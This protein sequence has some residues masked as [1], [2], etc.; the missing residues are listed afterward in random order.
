LPEASLSISCCRAA[1]ASDAF[2]F[3]NFVDGPDGRQTL[4]GQRQF[5]DDYVAIVDVVSV[6]IFSIDDGLKI[7]FTAFRQNEK[8]IAERR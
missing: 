4:F 2:Q 6:R 7:E 8:G 5:G 3:P 1:V